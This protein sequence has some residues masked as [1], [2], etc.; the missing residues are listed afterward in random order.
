M[1]RRTIAAVL[2]APIACAPAQAAEKQVIHS[3]ERLQLSDAFTCEGATFGDVSGDRVNDIVAGPWW[4]QGPDFKARHEIYP[5]KT[6][7]PKG[8]SDNFF[9]FL[10]DFNGDGALDLFLIGFPGKDASW[11]E[12]PKGKEGHWRRHLVFETVDNESPTFT[13]LTGDGRPDLVCPTGDRY[14]YAVFD[15]ADPAKPWTFVPVGEKRDVQRFTHGMGVGDVN[16]DGRLDILEKAGWYEQPASLAG[17]TL[18][19]YHPHRFAPG[20]GG[21]QMY[22]YD[23]NGDGLNDVITSLNAHGF[24]LVWHEQLRDGGKISFREHLVMGKEPAENRYGVAFAQLHGIDLVDMDGDGLKDIVTGK[25]VWAHWGEPSAEPPGLSYWFKLARKEKGEVDLV[26]HR[27]DDGSGVGVQ[28][29]AG[30]VDGDRLPDVVV[31]NKLGA[32]FLRHRVR[33]VSAAEWRRAQPRALA[34]A[35]LSPQEAAEAMAVPEGFA[36]DLVAGE[37]DLH[38]PVAFAFDERGRIWAAEAHTYPLRVKGKEG[39]WDEGK[40]RI[41]VFADEDADGRFET[42]K[43]FA[44]GLNLVSGLEVG[45]GGAWV[46]AAPYLLFFPDRDRDDRP[47]GPPE[48][49][50][51]GWGFEDTHETLNAFIW[52][53]DGWLYGCHG[54]FTHSRVGKP[55]TPEKDRVP[56]NAGVWRYHPLRRDFEVFAWGTSN[57]W[58]VDFNDLGQ[59]F[60]TA[61]VIPH[62]YHVV[63]GARYERQS[64]RHFDEHGFWEITTIADHRHYAGDI[65]EH[66]WWGHE[67]V[68]PAA[69]LDA[70]GGHAHCGAMVYLGD[71]FPAAYR[72]ALFLCNVHGNRVNVD[73]LERRGSGYVGRHGKDFLVANDRWFRGINLKTGPDGAVYLI[74]WYD[75]NACHRAQP[76]IW[77]RTSGRLYRVSHGPHRPVPVDL[78]RLE[79]PELAELA[80]HPN[81]WQV[82]QARRLLQERGPDPAARRR[83][84]EVFRAHPR[85]D[86]KLRALWALHAAGGLEE[87]LVLEAL[88]SPHE[89]LRAWALQLAGEGRA[90]APAVLSRAEA[91]AREDPSPVVRLYLASLLQRLPLGERWGI[92]RGLAARA[93]DSGDHN[94][95]YLTWYGIEPLVEADPKQALELAAGA[96]I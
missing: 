25:R 80:L 75:K 83:L 95:P 91:L 73:H 23:L 82:R 57:P 78:A 7:D 60:L 10:H 70:G 51:D 28:V 1:Q 63:Q 27:I 84:V 2:C 49:L 17:N 46:G 38:Q 74:D 86:R 37:P 20:V 26:P 11:F 79:A 64:G 85:A 24:G 68:T 87:P 52:G 94:L 61:C 45:F 93:E 71:S 65:G 6:Y 42:R 88:A 13:D 30:D 66:A 69:T 59:A 40:D 9:P 33:E 53:P 77:D 47:D 12:N 3:F 34:A 44:E 16:G 56:L 18:W 62:L 39:R 55:G 76:E 29:V 67:P 14:G 50:L 54:V 21:A 58:G 32:F 41:V 43:V 89:H 15:P 48:V 35:G 90:L 31:G 4:Y 36:V 81:D 92:A 96:R 72:D 8:Y 5:P 22:A 19:P